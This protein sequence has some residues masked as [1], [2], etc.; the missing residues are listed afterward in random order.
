MTNILQSKAWADFQTALGHTVLHG[1]G[2]GFSWQAT[3]EGNSTGR[4]LYTPYGPIADSP[5]AFDA[6]LDSLKAAAHEHG[7]WFVRVEPA[8]AQ[9]QDGLETPEAALRRRGLKIAPRQVQP[10]HTQIIDLDRDEDAILKDMKSTKRNLHRN[11]HKKGVTFTPSTDPQ[12]VAVL[13]KYLD[14]TAE[15][16]NF[17]RQQD[18]YLRTAAEVL[19]PQGAGVLYIARLD[20]EP[21]G[22]AFAYDSDDTRTYAHAAMDSTHRKLSAGSALVVR[23]IVDAREKGLKH[24][25]L[26]GTAP[27][28]AGPEHEW[29]GFTKFKQEFG[30]EPVAYP[31]TWDLPVSP[32]KYAAYMGIRGARESVSTAKTKAPALV[33]GLR[34]KAPGALSGLKQK[35]RS[36]TKRRSS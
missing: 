29:Y 24:F 21:I 12:D 15:R 9:I 25:D 8:F 23:M 11:I 26:F 20:G 1:E 27:E 3:V 17:N 14:Q 28:G 19:V 18:D 22:A 4:Y 7:C 31:G 36:V 10:G 2:Q 34:E 6:A 32:A 35:A 16:K 13:L 33:A 5:Q 30:G